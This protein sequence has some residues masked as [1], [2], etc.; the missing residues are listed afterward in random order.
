MPSV[1]VPSAPVPSEPVPSEPV[2]SE[3][4]P[5]APEQSALVPS[6]AIAHGPCVTRRLPPSDR[7]SA[8]GAAGHDGDKRRARQSGKPARLDEGAAKS[9]RGKAEHKAKRGDSGSGGS[10]SRGAADAGAPPAFQGKR[11]AMRDA[12]GKPATSDAIGT[13]GRF[14]EAGRN[15]EA[16][17]AGARPA[18]KRAQGGDGGDGGKSCYRSS[19]GAPG[20]QARTFAG[21]AEESSGRSGP[22]KSAYKGKMSGGDPVGPSTAARHEHSAGSDRAGK[23]ASYG[24]AGARDHAAN[25]RVSARE[26]TASSGAADRSGTRGS[27][28]PG[29]DSVSPA[30]KRNLDRDRDRKSARNGSANYEGRTGHAAAPPAVGRKRDPGS[31]SVGRSAVR[32]HAAATS[33]RERDRQAGDANRGSTGRPAAT[34]AFARRG[35]LV[36]TAHTGEV[37]NS[38]ADDTAPDPGAIGREGERIAKLLARAGVASRREVERMIAD[39]RVALNGTLVDTPATLLPGLKGVTVDGNPVAAPERTR[40]FRFHKPPGLITAAHDPAGRPT[41]Y[42]ALRNALPPDTPRV[43]PVGRLDFSTE[44]LLLLTNDGGLK[45]SL[46]LPSSGVMRAYRA[47]AFGDISQTQLEDL[48]EGIEIDGMHYG[49][50]DAN[51]ER[52]TGR[53]Q[54]IEMALSEGKNREV[55]RVLEHLGLQVSRLMRTAYGPFSLGDLPRG[56]A[57]EVPQKDVERLVAQLRAQG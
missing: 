4:V 22:A 31:D 12:S 32:N 51:L 43:M 1:P 40:L 47:R 16:G 23:S 9:R 50:I 56:A 2:P 20:R 13:S 27:A 39:G 48:I 36:G 7:R 46:E 24:K 52:R 21:K 53:N 35:H 34:P 55:R 29:A 44:G 57:D 49:R 25:S 42:T 54:W 18:R 14:D 38:P 41:I 5:S 28:R 6:R 17:H 45:R 15:G 37:A 8:A 26:R 3:P 19:P 33:P 11:A 30:G 10:V